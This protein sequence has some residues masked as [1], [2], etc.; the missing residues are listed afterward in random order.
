MNANLYMTFPGLTTEEMMHLQHAT[1]GMDE[2]QQQNFYNLY[3]SK[4]KSTQDMLLLCILGFFGLAGMHRMAMG[5]VGLGL[6][7]LFTFGLFWIGTLVDLLS[8]YRLT[9][10]YNRKM[11]FESCQIIKMGMYNY[12]TL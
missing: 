4:R 12:A 5:Q 6:V 10:E 9:N 3:A 7:Y 11:A 2:K 8:I 1:D